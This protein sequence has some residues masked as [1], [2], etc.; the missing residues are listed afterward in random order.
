MG[1]HQKKI[2]IEKSRDVAKA[3]RKDY[4]TNS[5][6]KFG[7]ATDPVTRTSFSI[8]Q[9][10]DRATI[11][12]L[13]RYDWLCRRIISIIP[14]DAMRKFIDINAEDE[15]I[16][17][18]LNKRCREFKIK[19]KFKEAM[20]LSRLY[21]G[22]AI[23]IGI[24]GS[25][26][27]ETPL[28]YD[29]I[30]E[31]AFLN[32]LDKNSIEIDKVYQNPLKD[33]Y[34]E[35]EIY[36]LTTYNAGESKSQKVN[37]KI[38]E[39]RIIKFDGEFL[40][41]LIRRGNNYWHDSVL[42]G[43]NLALKHY[44]ISL[45]SAAVL[46]QDFISKVL[47]IPNLADLLSSDEGVANLDLRIQYAIGNL[48]SL[49]IVLIGED[50]EFK[51]IQTPIAGLAEL[52]NLY[53]E[54][55]SACSTIPRT[56]LFGQ[57][58]GTLAGA[59]ETTR[60]YYDNIASYQDDEVRPGLEKM[61]KIFLRERVGVT[62]GKEPEWDFKFNSLW[63]ETDKEITTSRKMQ[64]QV[65]QIYMENKVLTPEEVAK[66]RFRPDGYSFQ[67]EIN[68]NN[69]DGEFLE[70]NE[71]ALSDNSKKNEENDDDKKNNKNKEIDE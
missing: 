44:G 29:K 45:Q 41:E 28:N 64:A 50:E 66:N 49:G 13:F 61:L 48:S 40:P 46:F 43:I 71:P 7:T 22:S 31:V 38:H 69:R 53:I 23:I 68:I 2:N 3:L 10:L 11:D 62:N 36:R 30:G 5:I 27:P 25:G 70:K 37:Q 47:K 67:T 33:N 21:G 26:A 17:R 14:S 58:L 8:S 15:S 6:N 39:S 32:V 16:V 57:S 56:R 9:P 52:I 35:P 65:D 19:K 60:T 55:A 18:Y 63:S 51:K 12:D 20:I 59:T 4:W 54:V 42:Q 34:G 1:N 24:K